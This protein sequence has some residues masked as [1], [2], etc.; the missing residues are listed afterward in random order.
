[1]AQIPVYSPSTDG[2]PPTPGAAAAGD[3]ARCGNH[4]FLLVRNTSAASVDV[5]IVTPATLPTG[6]AYPDKVVSVGAGTGTGNIVPTE[7]WIPLIA[8]YADPNTGVAAVN[9][10]DPTG[11][12]RVVVRL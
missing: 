10:S 9:Y 7:A 6:D 4:S 8:D 1:M 11:L 2:A 5:T 3:T 12:T